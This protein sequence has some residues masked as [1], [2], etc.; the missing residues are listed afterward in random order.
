MLLCQ[1]IYEYSNHIGLP[2]N[3][4]NRIYVSQSHAANHGATNYVYNGLPL[5]DY[6]CEVDKDDYLLFLGNVAR[7]NKGVDTA[8]EIAKRTGIRL[9]IAGGA[10]VG[11]YRN[12]AANPAKHQIRWGSIRP[13]QDRTYPA[14][15]SLDF[16]N[17]LGGA[18]RLGAD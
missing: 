16:S 17:S 10:A 12:L 6:S 13:G 11:M 5:F 7:G 18:V 14:G 1:Y 8:I 9:V 2:N 4:C 3:F 15:K